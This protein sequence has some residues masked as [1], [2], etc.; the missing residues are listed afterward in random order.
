MIKQIDLRADRQVF[1]EIKP[2]LRFGEEAHSFAF[3][4]WRGSI[5]MV[6]VLCPDREVPGCLQ[7]IAKQAFPPVEGVEKIL[8]GALIGYIPVIELCREVYCFPLER[9][10]GA[11]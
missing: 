11:G 10:F 3:F 2:D 1:A 8:A 5:A 7:L 4:F 9:V 6:L